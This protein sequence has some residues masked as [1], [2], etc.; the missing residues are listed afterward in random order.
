MSRACRTHRRYDAY[1]ILVRR[2]KGNRPLLRPRH[3][4][5]YNIRMYLK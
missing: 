5:K 2:P 1:T 3:K 4:W